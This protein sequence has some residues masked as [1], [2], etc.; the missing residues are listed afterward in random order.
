MEEI[1][2]T[3]MFIGII[4]GAII[5]LGWGISVTLIILW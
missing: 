5:G 2:F 1:N 4:A 3:D